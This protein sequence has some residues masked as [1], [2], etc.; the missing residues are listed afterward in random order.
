MALAVIGGAVI[1][2]GASLAAGSMQAGAA[3]DAAELQAQATRESVAEQRRQFNQI[4]TDF[5]PYR[6]TG[7]TAL[8]EYGALYGVGREGMLSDEDMQAARDR[9]KTTPGY[10]FRMEEGVRALDRSA[11]AR[12]NLGGGGYGRD[13]VKFGQGIGAEEFG[14]YANRL[15]GLAS[16]GQSSSA[17]TAS[18][19]MQ[20]AGNISNTL[21]SG[22]ANEGNAILQAG[23]ARASGYAGVGNAASGAAQNFMFMNAVQSG[24]GVNAPRPG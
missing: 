3:G 11:S 9:F 18:A 5:A 23:T 22:A 17:Q 20:S 16:M 13:L 15:A 19:G 6:E 12:G 1:A 14:N 10:E 4:R 2:G 8:G 24:Y 21:M 7:E